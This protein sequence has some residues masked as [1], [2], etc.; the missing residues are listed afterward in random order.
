MTAAALPAQTPAGGQVFL[1]HV[2]WFVTDMDAAAEAFGRLG[3]P[4]TPLAVHAD[5]RTDGA[6]VPS[7]TSNRCAM[8]ARGYL[9]V[10]VRTPGADT[11]LAR[12]IDAALA[13]REGLHLA[14]FSVADTA[15][16][17]ERLGAA[18][19]APAPPVALRRPMPLDGGGEGV[20]G[21]SVLRLARDDM[22]EGRVQIL[23]HETP[24]VAWQPS[25]T[26]SANGADLLS[27][28]LICAADA[29][30]TAERYARF[31][32]RPAGRDGGYRRIVLDRGEIAVA[33]PAACRAVLPGIGVPP[34]PFMAAAA[35]RSADL[36]RT[37]A[38]LAERN[39][40]LLADE[41]GRL[42][43]RPEAGAGAAFVLHASGADPFA[44]P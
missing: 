25:A 43:V 26:A 29:D 15:S 24:D 11:P 17:A 6:K 30:E 14:A 8:I 37:R 5:A 38:F 4:M 12:Q 28:L 7:G 1:D 13:R 22:P 21:F 16:A 23:T 34:P 35:V 20:A 10:L 27:G 19:F 32:G 31:T 33:D 41:P 9:E 2:G 3:F 39:V 36:G 18:G 44:A 40:P 42:V